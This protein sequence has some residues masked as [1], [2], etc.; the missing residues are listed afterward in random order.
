MYWFDQT[1]AGE[2]QLRYT[3]YLPYTQVDLR[4]ETRV[5]PGA[6]AM[7]CRP[8]LVRFSFTRHHA[9]VWTMLFSAGV[10]LEHRH[11]FDHGMNINA[12]SITVWISIR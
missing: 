8:T 5:A 10:P 9:R 3:A 4:F 11:N 7:V 6:R 1:E 2:R 12:T